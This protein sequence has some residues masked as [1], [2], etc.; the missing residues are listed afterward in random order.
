MTLS[1][2]SRR[3]SVFLTPERLHQRS[4]RPGGGLID[5][6]RQIHESRRAE[7]EEKE[8]G[9]EVHSEDPSGFVLAASITSPFNVSPSRF[10]FSPSLIGGCHDNIE[11]FPWRKAEAEPLCFYSLE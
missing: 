7:A 5:G 6:F 11:Q 1:T 9:T 4:K 8:A 2:R 10:I 3:C